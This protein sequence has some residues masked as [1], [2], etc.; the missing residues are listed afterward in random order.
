MEV[1]SAP[2]S[3]DRESFEESLVSTHGLPPPRSNNGIKTVGSDAFILKRW[4]KL[5]RLI[6]L[7]SLNKKCS[8]VLTYT[9]LHAT[10]RRIDA[11]A[12][13]AQLQLVAR[14]TYK[15]LV[16]YFKIFLVP[17]TSL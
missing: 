7:L 8:C 15:I 3:G 11:A 16:C 12:A 6:Q 5:L 10:V 2:P 4:P 14:A 1:G 17:P 13:A 9:G